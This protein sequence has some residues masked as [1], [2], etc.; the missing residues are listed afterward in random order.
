MNKHFSSHLE[1]IESSIKSFLP[2]EMDAEWKKNSFG[3]ESIDSGHIFPLIETTRSLVDLGGKRWRPLLLVLC[4]RA[5][6]RDKEAAQEAAYNLA[7]L[8]EFVHTASL[9]H[10]D[11]EDNSP[12]RRGKPSAYILYGTDTAINAGSWLFFEAPLCIEKSACSM[13]LKNRLYSNY[14]ME[15]RRLHLGQ[16]MD[17]AWHRDNTK[18]PSVQEYLAMVKG[19]TGTLASLAARMGT[20]VSGADDDTIKK[21][22][23]A[24]SDIG[25]GFQII[26]DVINLTTGN[27]GKKRGDDIVEGKKSLPVLE[28]FESNKNNPEKISRLTSC[29]VQ[30]AKEGIESPAVE[31]AISLLEQDSVVEKAGKKG[32]EM[33][34]SGGESFIN[35][36]GKGNED[37]ELI[38]ELFVSMIPENLKQGA[39]DKCR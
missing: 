23:E 1:K 20:L 26:D 18:V 31:K 25:A 12:V 21:A 13:E 16:A 2:L 27:P 32:V 10:D 37:A 3:S 36:F 8:V 19:K 15:L 22:G 4:A 38:K 39:Q 7:P 33:I 35:L 11:I 14:L 9:I 6:A 17:I 28:F 24:A 30:A 34:Y 5:C 29:F